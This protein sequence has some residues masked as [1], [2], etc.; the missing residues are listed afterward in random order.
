MSVLEEVLR[1]VSRGGNN[2]VQPGIPKIYCQESILSYALLF[3]HFAPSIYLLVKLKDKARFQE[4]V[5]NR[6]FMLQLGSW[7]QRL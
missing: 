2:S 3:P 1:S 7:D 5:I 6:N 4:F